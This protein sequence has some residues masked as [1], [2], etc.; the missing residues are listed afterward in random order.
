[1]AMANE[2]DYM[3]WKHY[4]DGLFFLGIG[5]G[6]ITVWGLSESRVAISDQGDP[7]FILIFW[8]IFIQILAAA[9]CEAIL[10]IL[11]GATG[12]SLKLKGK[13]YVPLLEEVMVKASFI[14]RVLAYLF[15]LCRFVL[16]SVQGWLIPVFIFVFLAN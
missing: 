5:L 7:V 11:I 16:F 9:I 3:N 8:P 10:F 15:Y 6:V 4:T 14:R 12:S 2:R 1:M 13:S